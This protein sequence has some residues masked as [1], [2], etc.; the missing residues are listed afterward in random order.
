MKSEIYYMFSKKF[1]FVLHCEATK[2]LYIRFLLLDILHKVKIRQV[3]IINSNVDR[4]NIDNH[5]NANNNINN[6][7]NDNK[8]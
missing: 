5:I 2:W 8:K 4:N 3:K 7:N 1:L 6:N